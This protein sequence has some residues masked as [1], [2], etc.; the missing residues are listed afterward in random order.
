MHTAIEHIPIDPRTSLPVFTLSGR[1]LAYTTSSPP[2]R[3]GPE[4]LGTIITSRTLASRS[5]LSRKRDTPNRLHAQRSAEPMSTSGSSQ[6]AILNSAMG[7][8]GVA[9]RGVWAGLKLGAQAAG[10]AANQRLA[11]SAPARSSMEE[12]IA[13]TEGSN[14]TE[15]RSFEGSSH[16]EDKS[17]TE[18]P[19]ADGQWIKIVDL[20]ARESSGP[21]TIAH[22][23]LP[24]SK[25]L[26]SPSSTEPAHP[27]T[28]SHLS[29]SPGGTSLFIA[30][31]DGRVFHIVDIHPGGPGHRHAHGN[32]AVEEEVSGDVWHMYELRRGN[33]AASVNEVTWSTDGRWVG[34]ATQRGTVR[35][36]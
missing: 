2:L 33:T 21:R 5:P 13:E 16:M 15:S 14:M 24:R 35:K 36:F 32:H 27:H 17:P 4:N 7:L 19:D 9:A 26:V 22:F 3:P 1:L 30:P 11:S 28:I 29:F 23:R 12:P 10:R 8:G 34:V 31:R 6:G 18:Q 25:P 20:C